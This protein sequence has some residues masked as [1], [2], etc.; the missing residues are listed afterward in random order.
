MLCAFYVQVEQPVACIAQQE[1]ARFKTSRQAAAAALLITTDCELCHAKHQPHRVN[2][3]FIS[4]NGSNFFKM[5]L[6]VCCSAPLCRSVPLPRPQT[7]HP[8]GMWAELLGFGDYYYE[9]GV[10]ILE[11]CWASRPLNGGLM[12]L[13]ALRCELC[14]GG[15]EF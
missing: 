7:L 2:G 10:Q 12:E 13:G 11:A 15:G 5:P 1:Q 3:V 9:L 14:R 4:L 8:Q 6:N